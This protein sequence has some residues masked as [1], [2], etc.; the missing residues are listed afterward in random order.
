MWPFRKKTD[1]AELLKARGNAQKASGDAQGAI[2]SYRRA[3]EISP[4]YLPALYNLGLTLHELSRLDEAERCFRRVIEL[5]PLDAEALF[6]LGA[7]LHK[8]SEPQEAAQMYRR[9]LPR[10]P[11]NPHLWLALG[12]ALAELPGQSEESIRCQREARRCLEQA[13]EARNCPIASSSR[14]S[15]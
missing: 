13:I 8:R 2:A 1:S 12:T 9:A 5:D 14:P 7:L 3:L 15:C 4:G 6:H 11:D 10:M